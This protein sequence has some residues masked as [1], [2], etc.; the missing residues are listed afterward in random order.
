MMLKKSDP[1]LHFLGTGHAHVSQCYNTCFFYQEQ[2]HIFL[3]DGGGGNQ[4]L[5]QLQNCG[6][7]LQDIHHFFISHAHTDH[8]LGAVWIVR[9]YASALC[10]K[11]IGEFLHIYGNIDV[12]SKLQKLCTMLLQPEYLQFINSGIMLH[13][14]TDGKSIPFFGTTIEFFDLHAVTAPQMGFQITTPQGLRLVFCGDEPYRL[15]KNTYLSNADWAIHESTLIYPPTTASNVHA[16]IR[17]A[18]ELAEEFHV[19]NLILCHLPDDQLTTRK[20]TVLEEGKR[21]FSGN[22]FCPDDLDV[23]SL[24]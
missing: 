22:L 14:L 10:D 15:P 13:N 23:I 8:L 16:C 18:C 11:K 5:G 21:Y 12:L 4:I 17:S 6:I 1:I 19:R 3:V 7:S 24:L 9:L 2:N 20:K